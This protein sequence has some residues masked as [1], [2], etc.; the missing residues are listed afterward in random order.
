[1]KR[2]RI[3]LLLSFLLLNAGSIFCQATLIEEVVQNK[4]NQEFLKALATNE[5]KL[6]LLIDSSVQL[7]DKKIHRKKIFHAIEI[8][9]HYT[10]GAFAEIP[11]RGVIGIFKKDPLTILRYLRDH[12]H[13][14][15]QSFLLY[16]LCMAIGTDAEFNFKEKTDVVKFLSGYK[17]KLHKGG[18]LIDQMILRFSEC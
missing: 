5:T 6:N 4:Q 17:R 18:G 11:S 10:D 3:V 16:E 13:S 7:F 1:M 15:I 14:S 2:N 12:R 8:V 9:G